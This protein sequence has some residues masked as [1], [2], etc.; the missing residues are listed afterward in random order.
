LTEVRFAFTINS[1]SNTDLL[2]Q[3]LKLP[4]TEKFLIVDGLL[5]SLDAPDPKLDEVWA[6][7]ALRRL[8]AYR[9]GEIDGVPAEDIFDEE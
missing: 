9:A 6:D 1:M 3:A 8:A 2:E 5:K 7:E 4:A